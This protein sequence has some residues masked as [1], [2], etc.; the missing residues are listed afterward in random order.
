[1]TFLNT[2]LAAANF[3]V[4]IWAGISLY[5]FTGGQAPRDFFRMSFPAYLEAAL[6]GSLIVS[7]LGILCVYTVSPEKDTVAGEVLKFVVAT[8][9]SI[10]PIGAYGLDRSRLVYVST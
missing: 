4:M 10:V 5:Y 6:V 2:L 1:M 7:A 8:P 3:A 9:F